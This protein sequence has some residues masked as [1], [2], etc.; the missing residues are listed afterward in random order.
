MSSE[1][2]NPIYGAVKNVFKLM[3]DMDV[4]KA[5]PDL[6]EKVK[7]AQE[8]ANI[9]ISLTGDLSGTIQYRFPKEVTL[10]IVK[11]MS[12]MD[13]TELDGFVTSALAE[14]ANIISGNAVTSLSE[15]NVIC[16]ILPPR[17]VIDTCDPLAGSCD[18][19]RIPL[20]TPIG[21]LEIDIDVKREEK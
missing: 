2:V 9:L 14:M 17:I 20:Q 16:D 4:T 13:M 12:G 18:V 10:E 7:S 3:L 8:Q 19:E 21:E 15:Q 11:I 5:N 1:Y 6:Q